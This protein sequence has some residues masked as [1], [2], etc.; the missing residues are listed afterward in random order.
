MSLASMGLPFDWHLP[1]CKPSEDVTGDTA[2]APAPAPMAGSSVGGRAEAPPG[3]QQPLHG[4]QG[5]AV[6]A[7]SPDSSGPPRP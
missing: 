1:G 6:L 3:M 5:Q 2:E 4:E 7:G